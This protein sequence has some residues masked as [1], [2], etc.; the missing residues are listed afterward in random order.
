M[1]G[2]I[3]QG[4]DIQK[5][6]KEEADVVVIGSG[7]GGA[8]SASELAEGGLDVVVLEEGGYYTSKDFNQDP[9]TM[10]GRLYRDAG[11]TIIMG[12]PNIVFSEGR[13]VGGSTVINGGMCWRTPE[14]I[15]KK[16]QWEYGL[17][18]LTPEKMEPYF[19]KVEER[20]SVAP[21]HPDTISPGENM[22]F[23]AARELGYFVSPNR[24]NQ[25]NCCGSNICIFG[26]PDDRKQSTL[27]SYI[28]RAVSNGARVYSD[29]K[30]TKI[31]TKNGRATGVAGKVTDR[32]TGRKLSKFKVKAKAVVLAGGALQ[33][34][35]LLLRNK[36]ANSSGMVGRNF[37]CHPN[38][39]AIGL[40]EEPV[41][42][43]KGVHQGHQVHE[44][45][46]EGMIVTMSGVHPA[47]V[48]MSFPQYGEASLKLMEK[49]NHMIIGG[50][51][52]D[53]TTSG[54]V[55]PGPFGSTLMYYTIDEMERQRLIRG[56]TIASEI[57]FTAGAKSVVL[58][59]RNL[60]QIHGIDEIPRIYENY[61]PGEDIE[62]LT[63]HAMGTTRMGADPKKNVTGPWGETH[64]VTN[65]FIADA[66]VI[67]TS[68]GVNP[69]ETIM[70]LATRTCQHILENKSKYLSA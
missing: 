2:K 70:A 68:L 46:D 19:E 48:A 62:L 24:R 33:T 15:L 20:I 56:V 28:P 50:T 9:A 53:D 4:S 63:V 6:F 52:V 13:C 65:L 47:L 41:Y 12:K 16:W 37:L 36:L 44:F 7:A 55:K 45:L 23:N 59:F 40:F 34:P 26:C 8:C 49:F 54:R 31:M 32:E 67:P 57:M 29:C 64:D 11:A 38:A 3:M 30:V 66:G 51:L 39:K 1:A 58:P 42:Y 18:D 27:I 14:K 22:F 69:Q 21:Q 60:E 5:G 61:I 25:K 17:Q 35:V 43:W 10:T